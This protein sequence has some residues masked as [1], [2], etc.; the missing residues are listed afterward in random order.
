MISA[1]TELSVTML[2]D[3]PSR[4]LT[5]MREGP[6]MEPRALERFADTMADEEPEPQTLTPYALDRTTG[7]YVKV[8]NVEGLLR[9]L[10]F[11]GPER[12]GERP[13]CVA[14][15]LFTRDQF[16]EMAKIMGMPGL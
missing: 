8:R 15:L 7:F 11:Q 6:G 14:D 5:G 9:I 16:Q 12:A 3:E 10:V 1:L 13:N 2:Y 4:T